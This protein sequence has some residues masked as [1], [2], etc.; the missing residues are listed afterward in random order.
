MGLRLAPRFRATRRS[1]R[2]NDHRDSQKQAVPSTSA[3]PTHIQA[4]RPR[5]QLGL[6]CIRGC[7]RVVDRC[8]RARASAYR[9]RAKARLAIGCTAAS[10]GGFHRYFRIG[11]TPL[12]SRSLRRSPGLLERS[13]E[14]TSELQALLRISYCVS[15]LKKKIQ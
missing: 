13:E 2:A 12:T 7:C 5:N 3:A 9:R 1:S 10:K 11:V 14:H 6:A 8:E 15:C 4:V